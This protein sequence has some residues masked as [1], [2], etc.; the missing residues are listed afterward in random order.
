MSLAL[1][2]RPT[3]TRLLADLEIALDDARHTAANE[4]P[5]GFSSLRS[6]STPPAYTCILRNAF[7]RK[8]TREN[9]SVCLRVEVVGAERRRP[10]PEAL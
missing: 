9:A 4:R 3:A 5:A 8:R 1:E 10:E 2:R 6:P 7:T